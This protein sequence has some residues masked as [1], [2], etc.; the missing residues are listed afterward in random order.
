MIE[1]LQNKIAVLDEIIIKNDDQTKILNQDDVDWDSFDR[2]A[3]E[4]L[5]LIE[6][7][8]KLD[9][10]FERLFEKIKELLGT[11][12]GKRAYAR[13]IRTMQSQISIITE[14]SVSI[15]AVE[16]RNKQ[17]VEQKF[18][19]SH[20]RLGQS[21]NTSRVAMDYYKNMQQTHVV[22]PAFLDSKK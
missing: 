4:K 21:R 22:T 15:Q 7:M 13:Q 2:N 11:E 3:D 12:E 16:A 14:K 17:L 20:K 8:D 9:E 10:G 1:S 6:R 18:S 5:E 19:Q